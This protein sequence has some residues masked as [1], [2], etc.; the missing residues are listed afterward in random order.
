MFGRSPTTDSISFNINFTPPDI[1]FNPPPVLPPFVPHHSFI[2]TWPLRPAHVWKKQ[3]WLL[4]FPFVTHFHQLT[5]A[6]SS[7]MC[8]TW[9]PLVQCLQQLKQCAKPLEQS[10]KVSKNLNQLQSTFIDLAQQVHH[11]WVAVDYNIDRPPLF[12]GYTYIWTWKGIVICFCGSNT[13]F[14]ILFDFTCYVDPACAEYV[15]IVY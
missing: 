7:Q 13:Y 6:Q 10:K 8:L 14:R 11:I 5:R 12:D 2:P 4:M 3:S 15:Y 1:M 9:K